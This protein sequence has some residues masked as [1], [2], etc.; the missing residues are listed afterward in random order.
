VFSNP[1]PP[2]G[3]WHRNNLVIKLSPDD[4]QTWRCNE[5]SFR[6]GGYCDMGVL[7]DG[8]LLCYYEWCL[9][10]E[11]VYRKDVHILARFDRTWL[12]TD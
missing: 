11:Q 5:Y 1:N 12:L 7:P 8:T 3:P 4:G 9:D 6:F 2:Q 10:N